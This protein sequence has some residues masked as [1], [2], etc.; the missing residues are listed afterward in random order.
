LASL[1][2]KAPVKAVS[3]AQKIGKIKKI[4]RLAKPV[5]REATIGAGF[6]GL[7]EAQKEEATVDDIV[8]AMEKGALIAGS[9]TAG[10]QTLGV[11]IRAFQRYVK[12]ALSKKWQGLLVKLE[13][14]ATTPPQK[15]KSQIDKTL[16]YIGEPKRQKLARGAL[17]ILQAPSKMKMRL[18][19]RYSPLQQIER[20]IEVLLGRPLKENEK[21]YRD[22]RLARS[23][24][25]ARAERFV[26]DYLRKL[27]AYDDEALR[28]A[29]AYMTQLDFIDRAKLGQ[30]VPG[31]QSL[32]DLL[33]GLQRMF[34]EIP[35]EKVPQVI[36]IKALTRSYH[37]KLLQERVEAGLIS[38]ELM[39]TLLRTHPN[40]IPHNV[41]NAIDEKAVMGVADSLNVSKTDVMKAVGSLKNIQ[42]PYLATIQR[43]PIATWT[44]EKNKLLNNFIGAQEKYNLFPGMKRI[45]E[46]IK[47]A[48]GFGRISLFRGGKKE[49]WQVP[50]DIAIAIKN[51][52]APLTPGFWKVLT[53]PNRILKKFA[54]QYNLSFA[55]PNKFRDEQTALLTS[56]A[57]IKEL[58]QRRGVS[59]KQINLT[60]KELKE[61][62]RLSGGYGSSIFKEG[63]LALF[64]KYT[65]VGPVKRLKYANPIRMIDEV[66]ETLEQSTRL[67][68]F[69]RALM[70]GLSPRDAALVA[71]DAT[72]DFA[73]MG[74]WMRPI[75]QAIPFLNARVQ[76]FVNLPK[77]F[78]S[79]PETFARMQLYTA[80][81][82]TLLLHQHNRRYESYRN[83]SQYFKNR[84]WII[85][86]NETEAVDPDT[87]KKIL[88]P[89]FVTIPKGEGQ[90]LVSGPVQYFL[91]KADEMDYRKTSEMLADVLGSASPINFQSFDQSNWVSS[92][93]ASFG[94]L[95][96]LGAGF[97]FGVHP[98]Y[99]TQIVPE[100]RKKAEPY[101]QF[102]NTTPEVIKDVGKILNISPAK[103]EFF[104]NA[105]GGLTNDAVRFA[106]IIYGVVKDGKYAE[107]SL[108]QTTWGE[109]SKIPI[110][111]RF[112]REVS[113]EYS[114]EKEFRK[115]Q[116][117][118][119]EREYWTKRL[120][121]KDKAVEV[122]RELNKKKTPEEKRAYLASLGD[123][124][125]PELLE[126]IY[127]IKTSRQTVEV[128]RKTDP[129]EVRARYILLRIE[130]M[131]QKGVS[132]ESIKEFLKE[133]KDAGILTS[134][135]IK[136]MAVLS[137]VYQGP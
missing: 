37:K 132:K 136:I 80:V 129:A 47:P 82:P 112:L 22:A 6:Y 9:I 92:V 39:E 123:E 119:I 18:I 30:T 73:R 79:N 117:E 53:T 14:V 24:A 52:D 90:V 137:G 95:G 130:E 126:E 106:D 109:L 34:K 29:K 28:Y 35:E 32:D 67:E 1:G 91:E 110:A 62:Y 99:G 72:I 108:S 120:L 38:K 81:Y 116:K 77:A 115:K 31:G 111:R 104:V 33:V 69:R 63:E 36:Q 51:L 113:P 86:L 4:F 97:G 44:I 58:A 50:E 101:L 87:G 118:T 74:S 103:I 102:R 100:S 26:D 68:V 127:K 61:L 57:F 8:K 135:V 105:W 15:G 122:W 66:N 42:D 85:M 134:Q 84:Y 89:Q 23:V 114:P 43:T 65:K 45:S 59:P 55:L 133:L 71:R 49:I 88:I 20:R 96:A 17:R 124:L 128:L 25:N 2:Y 16:S 40:Y 93:I 107:K 13:K 131:K 54:T 3:Q 27:S 94:P 48:K 56:Q 11:G 19:D 64:K 83:V 60:A 41:L 75:N 5:A 46:G 21:I 70:R 78:V 76:G 125:T 10:A 121:Q 12:P 7:T 98:F